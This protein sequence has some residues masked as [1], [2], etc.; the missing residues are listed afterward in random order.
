MAPKNITI[1]DHLDGEEKKAQAYVSDDGV[2]VRAMNSSGTIFIILY[3]YNKSM[4][5]YVQ[6]GNYT[7]YN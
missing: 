3:A 4:K 5:C 1:Y 2:A 6:M 7:L